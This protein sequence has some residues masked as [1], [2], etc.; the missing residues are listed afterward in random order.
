MAGNSTFTTFFTT[1]IRNYRKSLISN[2]IGHNVLFWQL[3]NRGF[4]S[5]EKGGRSIVQPLLYGENDTV[6]SFRGYDIIDVSPQDGITAAEY[7][8]KYIA[9]SVTISKQEEFENSS[10][11]SRIIN[12]LKAKI[13]QLEES[14]RLNLNTQLFGDGTGNGSKDITGLGVAVEDGAAWSTY[15][16]IDSSAAGN[17]FWRNQYINFT[18]DHTDFGTASGSSVEGLDVMRTMYNNCTTGRTKPTLIL[19][20]QTLYEAYEAHYEGDKLRATDTKLADAGFMNL[21]FKGV[22]MVFDEDMDSEEM[23]FLNSEYL[24]LV[25][26]KGMNFSTTPFQRPHNQMA[27]TSQLLFAGN[28]VT[29]K[30]KVHG[31][32]TNFAV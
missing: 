24:K 2:L 19:T 10:D 9:G 13:Q 32:I 1:T 12:L 28:L 16:G 20:T 27:K 3:R 11:K 30:R 6:S 29:S 23:L 7:E 15:A 25:I 21:Q 8:W 5:E 18:S 31:R 14:M 22:P 17:E 26:G 4:V